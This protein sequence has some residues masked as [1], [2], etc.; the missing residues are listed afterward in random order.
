MDLID[1]MLVVDPE[2]RFTIDQ[3]LA[4]PW[5]TQPTVNVND[6]TGLV[7]GIAGLDVNRRAP[8]RER[9][10]LAS[11]NELEIPTHVAS[12]EGQE[13]IHIYTKSQ[14][15]VTNVPKEQGPSHNRAPE[16]FMNLGGKGDPQLYGDDGVDHKGKSPIRKQ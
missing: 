3:C 9:T 4:H 11:I 15:R 14:G 1:S 8:K 7:G 5:L 16:E 10:L 13:S 2:K 12:K 6:S